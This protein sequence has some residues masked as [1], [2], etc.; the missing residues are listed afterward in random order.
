MLRWNKETAYEDA[1]PSTDIS[2]SLSLLTQ[3]AMST[4]DS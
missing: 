1:I 4:T 3:K 2:L